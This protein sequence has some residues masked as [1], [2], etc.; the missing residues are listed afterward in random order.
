MGDWPRFLVWVSV[1]ALVGLTS[2]SLGTIALIFVLPI[3]FALIHSDLR[4]SW[5]GALVGVGAV[6]LWVAFQN[7]T[8]PGVTCHTTPTEASCDG[9]L[10]PGPWLAIGLT[11]TL[12]GALIVFWAAR[13]GRGR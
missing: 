2:L 1:G 13:R 11:L 7:R 8:G 5:P 6:F 10:D 12:A 4:R 9:M 3:A